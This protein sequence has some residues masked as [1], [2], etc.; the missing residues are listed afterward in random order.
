MQAPSWFD[1]RM[2]AYFET[3]PPDAQN[4]VLCSSS[5]I[6]DLNAAENG[7]KLTQQGPKEAAFR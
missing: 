4:A 5:R 6:T 2:R 7:A 3:L 1:A